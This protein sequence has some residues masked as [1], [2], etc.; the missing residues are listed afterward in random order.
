MSEI[1]LS[2]KKVDEIVFEIN[3]LNKTRPEVLKQLDEAIQLG[4]LSE[5]AEYIEAKKKLREID[6]RSLELNKILNNAVISD[7][8]CISKNYVDIFAKVVLKN[9][10]NNT[11]SEYSLVSEEE[12]SIFDNQISITSPLGSVLNHKKV[13][14]IVEL[15]A[16]KGILKYQIIDIKY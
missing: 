11:I 1:I 13:N 15:T 6:K 3:E 7:E 16:P 9:I 14:D 10:S 2:R 4:D 8:D 5:N 12:A